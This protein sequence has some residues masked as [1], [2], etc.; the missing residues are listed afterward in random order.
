MTTL[1]VESD[2]H[3][4][5]QRKGRKSIQRGTAPATPAVVG[6]TPRV[7]KLMA[8]AIRFEDL[9][10]TGAVRDYAELARLGHVTRARVTQ[11]MNL[12]LL[13]P[14]I[15]EELLF[16]PRIESGRDALCLRKLQPIAATADWTMQRVLWRTLIA[17]NTQV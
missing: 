2:F 6:R 8:L 5:P 15:Q 16:L 1:T 10:Q 14:D 12:L 17:A 7:T 3:I 4:T 11:M 13:A 9:V